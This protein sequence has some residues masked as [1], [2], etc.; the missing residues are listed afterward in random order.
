MCGL[1]LVAFCA[2]YAD[3]M[4]VRDIHLHCSPASLLWVQGANG[5]GRSTLLKG[6]MGLCERAGHAYWNDQDLVPLSTWQIARL[7]VGY[8]PEGRNVFQ[9]LTV[10]EHV[11]LALAATRCSW[12]NEH[13]LQQALPALAARWSQRAERLSGGEQKML[14]VVRALIIGHQLVLLDE[15][16][17]GLALDAQQAVLSLCQRANEHGV[18]VLLTGHKPE[19][20]PVTTFALRAN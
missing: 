11:R 6:L 4:V 10:A 17:E 14:A 18:A 19:N 16:C 9:G 13:D 8:A 20:W 7:G 12:C 5:D 2:G 15:P 3:H 1:Q